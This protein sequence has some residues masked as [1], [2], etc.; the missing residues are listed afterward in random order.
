VSYIPHVTSYIMHYTPLPLTLG[1]WLLVV[2][3][4][5]RQ[6]L[7]QVAIG[8]CCLVLGHN[9][10]VQARGQKV[11]DLGDRHG[12]PLLGDDTSCTMYHVPCIMYHVCF[13][14]YALCI[15]HNATCILHHAPCIIYH[16]SCIMHCHRGGG[17][18]HLPANPS[19]Q[20]SPTMMQVATSMVF[21]LMV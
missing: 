9:N 18:I 4:A 13:M 16:E 7:R 21:W 14:Q 3:I 15:I 8:Q 1:F 5:R 11:I 19:S 10:V 2:L 17:S 12:A 20:R 6:V